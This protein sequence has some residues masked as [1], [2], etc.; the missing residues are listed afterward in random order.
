[1]R[2]NKKSGNPSESSASLVRGKVFSLERVIWR[3]LFIAFLLDRTH[4]KRAE[5]KGKRF[6]FNLHWK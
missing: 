1:V 3:I 5:K 2:C 6:L 4:K